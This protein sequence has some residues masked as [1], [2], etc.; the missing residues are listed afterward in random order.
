MTC[1][2]LLHQIR[3]EMRLF[4]SFRH[5]IYY[6]TGDLH[7]VEQYTIIRIILSQTTNID[8]QQLKDMFEAVR[9]RAQLIKHGAI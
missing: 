9:I 6:N 4:D 1:R 2:T 8:V 7:I 3:N 5:M